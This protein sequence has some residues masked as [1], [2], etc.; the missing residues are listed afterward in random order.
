ML[1][2][3]KRGGVYYAVTVESADQSNEGLARGYS[4]V[5]RKGFA[6][7]FRNRWH[8]LHGERHLDVVPLCMKTFG[9]EYN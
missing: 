6:T 7:N 5:D 3:L 1:A 8:E 9:S 2:A 4:K